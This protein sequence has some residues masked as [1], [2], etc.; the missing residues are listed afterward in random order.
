MPFEVRRGEIYFADLSDAALGSEQS[1]FRP[2]LCIQNDC[3]NHY[4]P[5]TVVAAIT[6]K[7]KKKMPTHIMLPAF[8]RMEIPS[9][10]LCEQI[11]TIDKSRLRI[12]VGTL[13]EISMK[14]IDRALA[15]SVGIDHEEE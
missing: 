12:Y 2:V 5:T 1:G 4:S 13:D 15:V 10:V 7:P 6:S 14:G 3:G 9:V 11:R 8:R